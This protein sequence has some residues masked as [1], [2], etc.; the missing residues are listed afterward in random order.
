MLIYPNSKTKDVFSLVIVR[1]VK[2][3]AVQCTMCVY[4]H[5]VMLCG[6]KRGQS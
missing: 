6:I 1:N 5:C 3:C 2:S 4:M